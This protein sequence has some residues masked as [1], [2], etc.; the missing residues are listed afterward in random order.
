MNINL[1]TIKIKSMKQ[2]ELINDDFTGRIEKLRHAC[3]GILIRDGNVL[4]GYETIG[5]KYII[6]GGGVEEGET[7]EQCCEREMLEE[8][9]LRVR[10][11]QNYLEIAEKF[12]VWNHINHYFV[13]E[14]IEDT[15]V[16][17]LTEQE[18]KA[19]CICVWKPL[20]EALE[21]F[22][23]YES[24]RKINIADYGLYRRE[25]TALKE[26]KAFAGK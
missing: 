17:H 3:R 10:A 24:L 2:L 26:Y 13:C 16:F 7:L 4:L 21:I 19:G 9:G 18:E 15:G 5:K 1:Q 8:T 11:I 12:D 23:K 20:D 6:P 25:Y 22:G 14:F